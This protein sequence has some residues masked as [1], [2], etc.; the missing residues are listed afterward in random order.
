WQ[1]WCE[2]TTRRRRWRPHWPPRARRGG[3]QTRPS[4]ELARSTAANFAAALAQHRNGHDLVLWKDLPENPARPRVEARGGD[5]LIG[6]DEKVHRRV[7][8]AHR[9]ALLD[10][11]EWMHRGEDG[12]VLA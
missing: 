12:C 3:S 2:W 9:D 7:V 6:C 4:L 8:T 10:D 11:L 5:H 1:E